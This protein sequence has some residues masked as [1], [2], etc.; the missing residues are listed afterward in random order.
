MPIS[1]KSHSPERQGSRESLESEP[2]VEPQKLTESQISQESQVFQVSDGSE[3]QKSHDSD[4][5]QTDKRSEASKES[6]PFE[7]THVPASPRTSSVPAESVDLIKTDFPSPSAN[8]AD[9]ADPSTPPKVTAAQFSLPSSARSSV[10]S[11]GQPNQPLLFPGGRGASVKSL[12]EKF[13]AAAASTADT[14]SPKKTPTKFPLKTPPRPMPQE[15]PGSS[16]SAKDRKE[17]VVAEYTSNSP[18]PRSEKLIQL[19]RPSSRPKLG[20]GSAIAS[21]VMDKS[22]R[23]SLQNLLLDHS[24]LRSVPRSVKE[25][26]EHSPLRISDPSDY[27]SFN[28]NNARE[29][30]TTLNSRRSDPMKGSPTRSSPTRKSPS[31]S[32]EIPKELGRDASIDSASTESAPS[33]GIPVPT[34]SSSDKTKDFRDLRDYSESE[35]DQ[36]EGYPRPRNLSDYGTQLSIPDEPEIA[37][38]VP[39]AKPKTVASDSTGI[40]SDPS[41]LPSTGPSLSRGNSVLH[42]EIRILRR[43]SAMKDQAL[44]RLKQQ[45]NAREDSEVGTLSEQLRET[46]RELKMWKKRAEVAEKRVEMLEKLSTRMAADQRAK[47]PTNKRRQSDLE[48]TKPGARGLPSPSRPSAPEQLLKKPSDPKQKRSGSL[49]GPNR[50]ERPQQPNPRSQSPIREPPSART[51][52]KP[53]FNSRGNVPQAESPQQPGKDLPPPRVPRQIENGRG[54]NPERQDDSQQQRGRNPRRQGNDQPV[55][56]PRANAQLPNQDLRGGY[57]QERN[58]PGTQSGLQP[59]RPQ[60]RGRQPEP[61]SPQSSDQTK[62]GRSDGSAADRIRRRL[63][64]FDG[65]SSEHS[66]S[67]ESNDTVIRDERIDDN[68]SEDDEWWQDAEVF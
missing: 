57:P 47:S 34:R 62:S 51:P 16:K 2:I 27:G 26:S 12:A 24:T 4:G 28:S 50:K 55:T 46:K 13:N 21:P 43:D 63:Q 56:D 45:L 40:S 58:I 35:T 42:S 38:Y 33:Q 49:L 65:T 37:R 25:N 17:S 59:P 61:K 6:R 14:P 7:E 64:G 67:E 10:P 54:R 18:S 48:K 1:P 44:K 3:Q 11:N 20:P 5:A 29:T 15:R 8:L 41:L 19:K 22:P 32:S 52:Q 68:A 9:R 36:S 39:P 53:T 31:Q 23:R 60:S 30:P 66:S